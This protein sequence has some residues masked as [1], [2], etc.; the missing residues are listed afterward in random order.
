MRWLEEHERGVAMDGG[1]V[2]IVPGAVIFDLPVGGWDCR[3]TAEFGYAACEAAA[4][5]EAP[6]VGTVGAGVGARAGVLK[7]GIGT[8]STNC[9]PASP[10]APSSRST[11]RATSSTGRPVCHGMA[12]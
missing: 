1:V 2:P 10:S 8:A 6:A 3:P 4:G 12:N 7:G 9:R 11:A 5:G